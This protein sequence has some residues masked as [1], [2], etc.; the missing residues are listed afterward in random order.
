MTHGDKQKA[1]AAKSSKASV[2]KPGGVQSAE[3]GENGKSKAVKAGSKD[4]QAAAKSKGSPKAGGE[5]TS[6]SSKSSGASSAKAGSKTSAAKSS[7]TGEDGGF[8]N[9]VIGHAFK[10]VL[11]KYPNA[12]RKLTD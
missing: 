4:E 5:K 9:P 6:P 10:Q 3:G 11:Q 8:N 7:G 1:K 12:L 2:K